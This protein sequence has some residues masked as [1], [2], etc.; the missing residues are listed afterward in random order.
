MRHIEPD[1]AGPRQEGDDIDLRDG[2]HVEQGRKRNRGQAGKAQEIGA[3]HDVAAV[4]SIRVDAGD[5]GEDQE[6]QMLKARDDAQ[7]EG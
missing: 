2:E 7:L 5:Q 3:E 1:A 6:G 4:P